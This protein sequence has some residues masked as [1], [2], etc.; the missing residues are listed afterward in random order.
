MGHFICVAM[1]SCII[2]IYR[3]VCLW[4]N[5]HSDT[6]KIYKE[7]FR[8]FIFHSGRMLTVEMLSVEVVDGV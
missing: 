2:D 7:S 3:H 6:E 8:A 1:R 4:Y 5:Q